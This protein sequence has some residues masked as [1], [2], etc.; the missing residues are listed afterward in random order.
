MRTQVLEDGELALHT[1]AGRQIPNRS[2]R[3]DQPALTAEI[4]RILR[5]RHG[6]P[7]PRSVTASYNCV[8]L[9]F[10]CRRTHIHTDQIRSILAED[11]YR[12]ISIN[13]TQIG[14]IVIYKDGAEDS[15]VGIIQRKNLVTDEDQSGIVVLSKWGQFGEFS[16]RL[17]QVPVD[18][19]QDVQYWTDRI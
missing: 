2:G 16:H 5:D 12:Q 3:D 13:E 4:T 9:V 15:H 7:A 19:G 1:R 8:G 6:L 14:D 17:N 11:G 10:A 18:Y